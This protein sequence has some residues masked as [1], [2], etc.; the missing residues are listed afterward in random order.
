MK[1]FSPLAG[2][3]CDLTEVPDPV[4]SSLML[5]PGIAINPEGS[6]VRLVCPVEGRIAT[7]KQHAVIISAE[8]SVLLH[9]GIDT[10]KV[11]EGL[12]PLVGVGDPVSVGD[13]L[14]DMNVAK[15]IGEGLDPVT[16][17]TM[18]GEKEHTFV[19]A[20]APGDKIA[21]GD[22]IGEFRPEAPQAS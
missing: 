1:V 3:V 9:A 2:T 10:F 15:I 4:M 22:L 12:E 8:T 19:P 21:P 14:I 7:V 18:L 5:G 20:V 16:I 13:E 11:P 17:I 6:A